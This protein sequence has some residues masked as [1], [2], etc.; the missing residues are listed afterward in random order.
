MLDNSVWTRYY[1]DW[2]KMLMAISS[3][4]SWRTPAARKIMTKKVGQKERRQLEVP[5]CRPKMLHCSNVE[6]DVWWQQY[7]WLLIAMIT[8]MLPV[9]LAT[10]LAYTARRN[11]WRSDGLWPPPQLSASES[12][13]FVSLNFKCEC[14]IAF[15]VRKP[16]QHSNV[17][18][19]LL[20]WNS[21]L[22][23]TDKHIS[24]H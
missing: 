17:S 19:T 20:F 23:V 10:P 6:Q 2:D 11:R 12:A 14:H 5:N 16:F 15:Q 7:C 13:I 1:S 3:R 24:K 22:T 9:M 21:R 8:L 4:L 18:S